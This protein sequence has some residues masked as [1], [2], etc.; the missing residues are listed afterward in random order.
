MSDPR[1]EPQTLSSRRRALRRRGLTA[2]ACLIVPGTVLAAAAVV[3]PLAALAPEPDPVSRR[4]QLE[5]E[6]GP[7]RVASVNVKDVGARPFL[8]MTYTVTNNSG[9][10][11]L[12][13]PMF[14]LSLGDG[15]VTR[16]GRG[17]PQDV[18]NELLASTQDPFI[19]DQISIIDQLLQGEENSKRGLVV[20]PLKDM[21]PEKVTIYA[22]GFSGETKTV[23]SPV[24]DQ[25]FVLRKTLMLSYD[26]PGSLVGQKSDPIPL[27]AK[28]WIMR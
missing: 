24:G 28:Q 1:P 8:Y 5:I 20:W 26:S 21:S 2:L 18:T 4:W 17:V 19:V 7:L 16:S 9:D 27:R 23:Q 25:S 11:L 14:E 22:A 10:D 12:F 3:A 15:E 6:P 13:A